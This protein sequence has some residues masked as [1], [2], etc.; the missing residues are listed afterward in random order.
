MTIRD[1][2]GK[3]ALCDRTANQFDKNYKGLS[4]QTVIKMLNLTELWTK[5]ETTRVCF[6]NELIR[7]IPLING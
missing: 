6:N 5:H 7:K 4:S 3:I 1:A 2:I